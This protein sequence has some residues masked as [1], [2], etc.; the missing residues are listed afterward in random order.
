M[1]EVAMLGAC[2]TVYLI[3]AVHFTELAE[4]GQSF[5]P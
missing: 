1:A 4:V 2:A 3:I 5:L